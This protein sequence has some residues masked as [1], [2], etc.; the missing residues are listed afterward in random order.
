[1]YSDSRGSDVTPDLRERLQ[2]VARAHGCK[3]MEVDEVAR[4]DS[5]QH[6]GFAG[7]AAD[8]VGLKRGPSTV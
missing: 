2:A 6:R 7:G 1:M 5:P 3:Y 8:R 4:V